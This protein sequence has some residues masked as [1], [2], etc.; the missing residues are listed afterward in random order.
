MELFTLGRGNYTEKD[1][2]EA[3]R[4]FTGWGYNQKGEYQFRPVLHDDDTKIFFG[5]TAIL[6]E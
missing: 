4:A 2:K 5:K 3:A 1:I 6:M